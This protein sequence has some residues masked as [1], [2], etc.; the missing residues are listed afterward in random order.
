MYNFPIWHELLVLENIS[1]KPTAMYY[2]I[3]KGILSYQKSS[4]ELAAQKIGERNKILIPYLS[5]CG[6]TVSLH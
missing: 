6:N 4:V 5:L 1:L 3:K 2:P